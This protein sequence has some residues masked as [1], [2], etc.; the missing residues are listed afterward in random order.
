MTHTRSGGV[1]CGLAHLRLDHVAPHLRIGLGERSVRD[2]VGE[3]GD[4]VR[5][6]VSEA[7]GRDSSRAGGQATANTVISK[8]QYARPR[9]VVT[10]LRRTLRVYTV[11]YD[12]NMIGRDS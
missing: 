12:V 6:A 4:G 3:I 8:V 11:G 7:Q 9:F 2:A 10:C 5:P 1:G